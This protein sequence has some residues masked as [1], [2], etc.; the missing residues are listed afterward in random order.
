MKTLF[1]LLIAFQSVF[2]QYGNNIISPQDPGYEVF[3]GVAD[4]GTTDVFTGYTVVQNNGIVE[5]ST[6][7]Y[8][9]NYAVKF[10]VSGTAASYS[11][12]W[13]STYPTVESGKT[14]LFRV[15]IK[16][17][18]AAI[19]KYRFFDVTNSVYR[20][21]TGGTTS[22]I[23]STGVT[24]TIYTSY[25]QEWIIP[26]SSTQ[27]SIN[28]GFVDNQGGVCYWDDMEWRIKLDSLH[29][30]NTGNDAS[31][32]DLVNPIATITEGTGRGFY[33]GGVFAFK[34]GDSFTGTFTAQNN[35]TL[36]VYGGTDPVTISAI[37]A[38]GYTVTISELINPATDARFPTN[39]TTNGF[40]KL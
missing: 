14:Y 15:K 36:T 16:S 40:P 31:K 29:F 17:D 35:C 26:A 11:M 6:D 25:Q 27:Y 37:D 22:T 12:L 8:S 19:P 1:C 5:A 33:N 23:V 4:D 10:T 34:S 7:A 28:P 2:A 9:G 13:W 39:P 38:N 18:G 21:P 32:G 20:N 30:S 3:T 24:A